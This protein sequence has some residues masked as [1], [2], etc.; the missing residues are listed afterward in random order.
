VEAVSS[1]LDHL[2]S[3]RHLTVVVVM[4]LDPTREGG[5]AGVLARHTELPVQEVADRARLE[6]GQVL[7]IPPDRDL[8]VEGDELRLSPSGESRGRRLPIDHF[9]RSL[10]QAH[11]SRAIGVVLSGTGSDG[12]EGLRAIRA[13][14]GLTLAQAPETA[15]FDAMPRSAIDA[16]VVDVAA[17]IDE[18]ADVLVAGQVGV[19]SRG[20]GTGAGSVV[21]PVVASVVGSTSSDDI[22]RIVEL[23]ESRTGRDLSLHKRSSIARR[24]DR[25]MLSHQLT[26]IADYL[27]LVARMPEELD[28]LADDLLIGVTS[29]FRDPE[30]WTALRDDVLPGLL[31]EAVQ[32]G[33]V[34]RVWTP[35]C[36]TGEEAYTV[37]MTFREAMDRISPRPR[38]RLQIFATDVDPVAIEQA[39]S[40]RYPRAI[41]ADVSPERLARFFVDSD[42]GFRIAPDIRELVVFAQQDLTTD[43]PFTRI[44][45]IT[46]RNLLIYF[47]PELQRRILPLFH[48]A[49]QPGGV[50]VLGTAESCSAAPDL[51]EPVVGRARIMRRRHVPASPRAFE[52]PFP[53]VTRASVAPQPVVRG[54]DPST[55]Q[56]V[57]EDLLRRT[58]APSAVLATA[59]GDVVFVNGR[60]GRY[61]EPPVGKASLDLIA[62]TR[63]SLR[64]AVAQA[65]RAARRQRSSYSLR[66]VNTDADPPTM[67]EITAMPVTEPPEASSMVLVVF[68]EIG[69]VDDSGGAVDGE[70]ADRDGERRTVG[71]SALADELAAA[72]A[73]LR[74]AN[75]EVQ[76]AKQ[77]MSS[78]NEE[79]Q[80]SNEELQSANE[81]LQAAN[82]ELMRSKEEMQSMNEELR[83]INLELQA[84]VD[85]LVQQSDDMR[86]LL[87]ST[88][89]ATLFLDNGLGVRRFTPKVT[90]MFKLIPSDIGRAITDLTTRLVYPELSADVSSVL[91]DFTPVQR[92]VTDEAGRWF[93]VR[94]MPYRTQ[95][96]R[97]DGTVLT[98]TDITDA[99]QRELRTASDGLDQRP[100]G[101][102]TESGDD[103]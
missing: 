62:M 39:R 52:L 27:R 71:A 73:E 9:F 41:E 11:R 37:A 14:G 12:T 30:V 69:A 2:G 79:L 53:A 46:C 34:V 90:Q 89:I 47:E 17:P 36:S 82:E 98:F 61:L 8:D 93:S 38:V 97:I 80:S 70:S 92:E 31:A 55:L 7:V 59:T 68:S 6:P 60:T 26:S 16:D 63:E 5:L 95:D 102:P 13:A 40:G 83:T 76:I 86:N 44:D 24:I 77:E 28:V 78:M 21:A 42:G 94:V 3:P 91:R 15:M 99:K 84:R 74:A 32:A 75:E 100:V 88:D 54:T 103:A 20:A 1:L 85:E 66:A 4:H 67:V 57:V 58:F 25:R 101:G 23:L 18:L 96:R 35:A 10:A 48:H 81:E 22:T 43:P 87:D 56:A 50:L 64:A 33:G 72:Q 65:F 19:P 45:L 29:F 51:F 49:L